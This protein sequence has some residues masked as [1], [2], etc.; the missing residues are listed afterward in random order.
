MSNLEYTSVPCQRISNY[1]RL[2]LL[3]TFKTPSHI[4]CYS[5][6]LSKFYTRFLPILLSHVVF[7]FS[8]MS[9]SRL[10]LQMQTRQPSLSSVRSALKKTC[11]SVVRLAEAKQPRN[12]S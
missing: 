10:I 5:C 3:H 12:F 11:M 6:C 4:I 7:H 1:R 9:D 8:S 2:Q